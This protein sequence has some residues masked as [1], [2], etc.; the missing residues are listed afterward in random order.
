MAVSSVIE[1]FGPFLIPV[2]VF[3][4]GAAGYGVLWLLSRWGVLPAGE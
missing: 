2:V 1:T 4:L 3:V